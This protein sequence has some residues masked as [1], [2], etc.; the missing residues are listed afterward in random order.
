MGIEGPARSVCSR[1]SFHLQKL[2]G[3]MNDNSRAPQR[4][5][6]ITYVVV[7]NGLKRETS[8]LVRHRFRVHNSKARLHEDRF[9][10][11]EQCWMDDFLQTFSVLA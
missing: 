4:F 8:S 1:K 9:G 10:R 6:R 11:G 3:S 7:E 5:L 2:L